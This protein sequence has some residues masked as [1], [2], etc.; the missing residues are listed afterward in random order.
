MSGFINLD[1][2][3]IN[4]YLGHEIDYYELWD[5]HEGFFRKGSSLIHGTYQ[6]PAGATKIYA[7]LIWGD[8]L[9]EAVEDDGGFCFPGRSYIYLAPEP[10]R[11]YKISWENELGIKE[12]KVIPADSLADVDLIA[13]EFT[14][15]PFQ[16]TRVNL[17]GSNY[18][19]FQKNA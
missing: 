16:A 6:D 4:H 2:D 8:S 15:K 3:I 9:D 19:P 13:R 7:D 18:L 11:I 5:P 17:D 1:I 10:F 12:E 14:A